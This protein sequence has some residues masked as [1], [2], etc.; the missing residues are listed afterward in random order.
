MLI[1]RDPP[2]TI[3]EKYSKEIDNRYIIFLNYVSDSELV[4][5]YNGAI[6]TLFPSRYEG[7]GF[8]IIESYACGTPVMTCR[9]SSLNEVAGD[10]A[11]YVGE[12]DIVQM[13]EIMH[14]ACSQNKFAFQDK[15]NSYIS[16]FSWEQTGRQYIELYKR[17][18]KQT[19]K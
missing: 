14:Y 13:A 11:Y 9:N 12:D 5:L 15:I 2:S 16:R 19:K 7:F 6:C 1:W 10:Y 18:I 3:T 17:Y 4:D 8:P